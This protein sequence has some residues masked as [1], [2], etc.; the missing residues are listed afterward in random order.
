MNA[1]NILKVA[2]AIEKHS[3][4]GLAFHMNYSYETDKEELES[5]LSL[6]PDQKRMGS[7]CGAVACFIGWTN[8]VIPT[9]GT[10][11]TNT[12]AAA[13]KLGFEGGAPFGSPAYSLFYP[14][15]DI[16]DLRGN[17]YDDITP[18]QGVRVLRHLAATGKIDWSV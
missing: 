6:S 10:E 17:G 7:E 14:D 15:T 13:K 1:E 3:V 18:E 9:K 5:R 12:A 11:V 16:W 2:D 4:V 8:S